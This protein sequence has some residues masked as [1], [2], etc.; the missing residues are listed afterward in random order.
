[1]IDDFRLMIENRPLN[2]RSSILNRQSEIETLLREVEA[3]E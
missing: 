1:M 3:V 2:L